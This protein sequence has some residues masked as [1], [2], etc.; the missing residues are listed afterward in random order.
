VPLTGVRLAAVTSDD[1]AVQ[2]ASAVPQS[3]GDLAVGA[4]VPASFKFYLGRGGSS[5]VCGETLPFHVTASANE[6]PP[7][8]RSFDLSAERTSQPGPL[9]FGFETDFSGWTVTSGT[10]TRGAGGTA[11]SAAFSLRSRSPQQNNDCNAVISPL[12]RP[13][14]GSTLTMW[15]NYAIESGNFD[16]TVVR[17][18]DPVSGIKTLL[19]PTGALYD[20][21]GNTNLLCDN[22][23]NLKGWSG[24]HATWR[25]ASFDLSPFAGTNIQIEV[26][27]ST[28]GSALG[29]Q[30]F[31]FDLV[32]VTNAVQVNCD[33]QPDVCAPLPAEVSPVGDPVPLTL[34]KSGTDLVLSFSEAAGA[35]QYHVYAGT[36]DALR[37]GFYDHGAVAGLC[38]LPDAGPGDGQ[39]AAQVAASALPDAAYLLA[40]GRNAAGESP[41][42]A[43]GAG[44]PIP[45]A[46]STCP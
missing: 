30:G 46:L 5:A 41:Y 29:A 43:D 16:R 32:Q 37:R 1:P 7:S 23:G 12:I 39:V 13:S 27:Y 34:G 10:F 28:D 33:G 9:T 2:V 35:S 3:A 40:V 4:S 17:A 6:A 15:V 25:Q 45:L 31:W 18:V 22:L 42:G 19:T 8:V 44:H 36:L 11:G 26:R 14:A 38:G 21:T 24:S 20:T